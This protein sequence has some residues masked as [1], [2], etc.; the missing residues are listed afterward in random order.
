MVLAPALKVRLTAPV[1]IGVSTTTPAG[2]DRGLSV[3]LTLLIAIGPGL[4]MVK[5]MSDTPPGLMDFG[6]ND[7]LRV[8]WTGWTI[9]A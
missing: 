9:L 5:V 1:L 2:L 6:A 7:F 3:K 8:G 4:V